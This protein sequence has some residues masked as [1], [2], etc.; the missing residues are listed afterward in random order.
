MKSQKYRRLVNYIMSDRGRVRAD[1]TF[2]ICHNL[3]STDTEEI[4]KEFV[5]NDTFRKRRKRSVVAYHEMITFSPKDAD[6]LNLE[7]LEDISRKYIE[8]RGDRALCLAVP[9]LENK[10]LHVHFCFS[11]TEY[12]SPK[13]LRLDNKAFRE[14]RLEMERFQQEQYPELKNSL[15]YLN[16]WEKQ[17]VKEQGKLQLSAPEEQLKKRTGKATDK[18]QLSS[19][20]QHCFQNSASR[21]DFFQK[22]ISEG[23]ELYQY[24]NKV[25]GLLWK[26]RKFRFRTLTLTNTQLAQLEKG[27]DRMAE[28]RR[29]M[30]QKSK[31]RGLER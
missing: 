4:I 28:L 14:L 7:V 17:Q 27:M 25:N 9:H 15:V 20:V 12:R 26:G 5:A 23:L 22:L 21:D 6:S 30:N 13:T 18:E 29:I 1:N 8:L 3:R 11:G 19:L 16:A 24:R 31:E 10:S 2:T